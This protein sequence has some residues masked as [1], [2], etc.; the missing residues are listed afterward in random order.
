VVG[1]DCSV[2]GN[3]WIPTG[4]LHLDGRV[5]SAP[6]ANVYVRALTASANI[7]A[8]GHVA[9]GTLSANTI[10]IASPT[11]AF[12]GVAMSYDEDLG[13]TSLA[14]EGEAIVIARTLASAVMSYAVEVTVDE[15]RAFQFI[16]IN[17]DGVAR[18]FTA[19]VTTADAVTSLALDG[20]AFPASGVLTIT[21]ATDGATYALSSLRAS[22]NSTVFA[23]IEL[24]FSAP[25]TIDQPVVAFTDGAVNFGSSSFMSGSDVTFNSITVRTMQSTMVSS[26]TG[27]H[28]CV[29]AGDNAIVRNLSAHIGKCV[30]VTGRQFVPP[31]LS[32]TIPYVTM[33]TRANSPK[34]FGVIASRA[35]TVRAGGEPNMILVNSIGEGALWVTDINGPIHTGDLLT[36]SDVPGYAMRQDDDVMHSYTLGKATQ[37]AL[38]DVDTFV[39][40]PVRGVLYRRQFIACAYH[41]A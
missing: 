23:N 21:P 7:T 32:A 20:Q 5:L 6:N 19:T 9:C 26:L 34:V 13:S 36:T 33:C 22:G 28:L 16:L 15:F 30:S 14:I 35:D 27:Q 29:L 3:V 39:E 18:P 17:A 24:A 40:L 4:N 10:Y 8:T 31:E 2:A 37:D 12:S 25:I 41:A 38:F 1:A 11:I